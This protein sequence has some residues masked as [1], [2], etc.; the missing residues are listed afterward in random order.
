MSVLNYIATSNHIHLLIWDQGNSEISSSMQL[1]A[2][3]TAQEFN[4]RKKRRG[5]F[6]EDRYH[7]TAVQSGDH[8]ARCMTYID[9][10]MVRAGVV[11][12]PSEWGVS[13]YSEMQKPWLRKALIDYPVLCDLL[14][15]MSTRDLAIRLRD[16]ANDS[17]Q[18]S[19][20]RKCWT[21]ALRV[22]MRLLLM[23]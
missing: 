6:W 4:R 18:C 23:N 5:A 22:G 20:R 7:A 10:N 13:G 16:A 21:Q 3:R 15:E 14:G 8:L 11:T 9:L 2:S 12:S 17:A 19:I 1:D